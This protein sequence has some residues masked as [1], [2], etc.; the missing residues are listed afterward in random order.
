[1]MHC[2]F[3]FE[4]GRERKLSGGG[5]GSSWLLCVNEA[6]QSS[7][8]KVRR[9][10]RKALFVSPP[11][12]NVRIF[13][14]QKKERGALVLEVLFRYIPGRRRRKE[15]RLFMFTLSLSHTKMKRSGD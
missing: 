12:A 7:N 14:R 2:T 10:R 5:V 3:L 15:E 6:I 13:G 9:R 4:Q 11:F 1:M 8:N